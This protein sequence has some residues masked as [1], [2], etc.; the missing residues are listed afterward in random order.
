MQQPYTTN[1]ML[2]QQQPDPDSNTIRFCAARTLRTVKD[3]STLAALRKALKDPY[4]RED[5]SCLRLE[6]LWLRRIALA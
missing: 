2:N 3:R 4:Q 1:T 6:D 5:G